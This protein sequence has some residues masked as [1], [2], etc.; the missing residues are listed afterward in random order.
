MANKKR[1]SRY[2]VPMNRCRVSFTDTDGIPHDVEVQAASLYE[3]VAPAVAEFPADKL[4]A[5]W[6][7]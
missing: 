3:A 2:N 1:I 6:A 7:R 5:A 4:T